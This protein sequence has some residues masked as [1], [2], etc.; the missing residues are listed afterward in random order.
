MRFL[1]PHLWPPWHSTFQSTPDSVPIPLIDDKF[2]TLTNK[3]Q[4][5]ENQP[6]GEP[7]TSVQGSDF[8][9]IPSPFS[10]L[11]T[12]LFTDEEA[13]GSPAPTGKHFGYYSHNHHLFLDQDIAC[14][15]YPV[16]SYL[17]NSPA[18]A[19]CHFRFSS[20]N[21]DFFHT[22]FFLLHT[23]TTCTRKRRFFQGHLVCYSIS[24][25]VFN[26]C[27]RLPESLSD[28]TCVL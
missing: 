9:L 23:H 6:M 13:L 1:S 24:N 20:S 19:F 7:S 10:I 8:Y 22:H 3:T 2:C 26:V 27:A 21:F 16:A 14:S 5:W 25:R 4:F 28:L 12:A 15:T 17:P 18:F 11:P